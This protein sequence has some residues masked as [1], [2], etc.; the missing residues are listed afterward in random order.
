[1]AENPGFPDINQLYAEDKQWLLPQ[2]IRQ[3]DSDIFS[4]I[5][6]FA[7]H[8]K[9]PK[10][11][12]ITPAKS[13]SGYGNTAIN[14]DPSWQTIFDGVTASIARR[15]SDPVRTYDRHFDLMLTPVW[16]ADEESSLKSQ[17][18]SQKCD[19]TSENEIPESH[20]NL[21]NFP[22]KT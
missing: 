9:P 10:T 3:V 13:A 17:F 1:M 20:P 15:L 12:N 16:R 8:S 5:N 4:E 6:P 7:P 11:F 2:L 18:Q 14:H 21:L 19:R 22:E